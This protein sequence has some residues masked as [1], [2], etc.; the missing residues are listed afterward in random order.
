MSNKGKARAI[1]EFYAKKQTS[2]NIYN[3]KVDKQGGDLRV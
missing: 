3:M 1:R 2:S